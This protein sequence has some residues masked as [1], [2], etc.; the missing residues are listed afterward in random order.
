MCTWEGNYG[1]LDF[2]LGNGLF[3][4]T[5]S[6]AIVTKRTTKATRDFSEC[7]HHYVVS[8]ADTSGLIRERG[9]GF[10]GR[11]FFYR[12][13]RKEGEMLPKLMRKEVGETL[14]TTFCF[15]L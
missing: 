15:L 6:R 5:D 14:K 11:F 8:V 7:S 9:C 4:V 3:P 13:G 12:K 2:T 1:N 10:E